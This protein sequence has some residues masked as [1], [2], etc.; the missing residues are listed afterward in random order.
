MKRTLDMIPCK[1][2]SAVFKIFERYEPRVYTRNFIKLIENFRFL[3]SRHC[4]NLK[5]FFT[6][7]Q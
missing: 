2:G 5:Y 4:G 3:V 7:P 6:K 1:Y